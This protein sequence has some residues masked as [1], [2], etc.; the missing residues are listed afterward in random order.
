MAFLTLQGVQW[1][2]SKDGAA[3]KIVE[4]G[5]SGRQIDGS[6]ASTRRAIKREWKLKTIPY[7]PVDALM[8]Q[9]VLLGLGNHW[10][11]DSPTTYLYSDKGLLNIVATGTYTTAAPAPKF[12]VGCIQVLSAAA[13]TWTALLGIDGSAAGAFT[14]VVWF[15]N[16]ASWDGYAMSYIVATSTAVVYKNGALLGSTVPGFFQFSTTNGNFALV[17]KN[18]AGTLQNSFF[19][20]LVILPYFTRPA[21][22][23]IWS[24]A[25][26]AFAPLPKIAIA[27]DLITGISPNAP[28]L[29]YGSVDGIDEVMVNTGDGNGLYDNAQVVTFG[30]KEP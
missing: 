18:F 19:D 23:A 6:L 5:Y 14:V 16:G 12:G 22:L 17:G 11:F 4:I 26:A 7:N 24:S 25:A 21:D 1:N 27:G 20:D 2:V 29:V 15:W 10:S 30:L 3:P 28:S 13:L 9:D 8:F